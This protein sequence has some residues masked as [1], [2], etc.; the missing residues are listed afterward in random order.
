MDWSSTV[1]AGR[2]YRVRATD[3]IIDVNRLGRPSLLSIFVT[4][5]SDRD[6]TLGCFIT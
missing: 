2:H 1:R 5:D 6:H 3:Q 4:E